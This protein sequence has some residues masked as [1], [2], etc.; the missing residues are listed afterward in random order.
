MDINEFIARRENQWQRLT[1][2]TDKAGHDTVQGLSTAEAEEFFSLYRLASSDLNLVQTRGGV[3]HCWIILKRW[4]PE[5]INM[6][7]C[8]TAEDFLPPGG[9]FCGTIFR[10]QRGT[11]GGRCCCRR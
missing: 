4:W 10:L 3:P 8:R 11:N 5:R 7:P 6:W 2:L 1:A 9:I